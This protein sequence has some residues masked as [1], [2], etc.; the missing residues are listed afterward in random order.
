[1]SEDEKPESKLE[2]RRLFEPRRLD[3]AVFAHTE[4]IER[5]TLAV[6]AATIEIER[7]RLR[8]ELGKARRL[9][10]GFAPSSADA[11]DVMSWEDL[12]QRPD[13]LRRCAAKTKNTASEIL[14]MV[15]DHC[16][17]NNPDV[18]FW[19]RNYYALAESVRADML[20]MARVLVKEHS[21]HLKK[22]QVSSPTA[23]NVARGEDLRRRVESLSAGMVGK[24]SREQAAGRIAIDVN[25]GVPHVK[26]ILRDIYPGGYATWPRAKDSRGRA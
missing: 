19:M 11:V 24:M 22:K 23:A 2:G 1:M 12:I 21:E 16:V 7:E 15:A 8:P 3:E 17:P 18:I 20:S 25:R 4:P 10:R 9:A 13:V 14:E 26:N 5:A 6:V